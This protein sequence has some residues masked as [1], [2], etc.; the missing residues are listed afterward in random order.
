MTR[1]WWDQPGA[2]AQMDRGTPILLPG[3]GGTMLEQM[4]ERIR[5]F[6][7]EWRD[8]SEED[9][10]VALVRLFGTQLTPIVERAGRL[11]QK[12]LIEYLRVAG[13]GLAPPRPARAFVQFEPRPQN[14]APVLIPDGFRLSS[15]RADGGSGGVNWETEDVLSVGNIVLNEILAFD[16]TIGRAAK[17]GERLAPF[18]ERPVLGAALYLGFAVTGTPGGSIALL[19]EPET[20]GVPA[21]VSEGGAPPPTI[22]RPVLRWEALTARGFVTAAETR[23]DSDRLTRTGLT[24]LKLPAG[25]QA[26]RP[27]GGADGPPLHWLRLRFAS[28]AMRSPSRLAG[29]YPHVVMAVARET[30]REEYPV[31]EADGR[32][33][34]ARLSRTPVLTGSVVLE[35]DEGAVGANLF[36]IAAPSAS[37]GFRRWREVP[38]LAGQRPDARVFTLDGATGTIRFGD[39]REGMSPPQGNRNIA[40]RAY[41]TSLGS[42]GNVGAGGIGTIVSQLAGIQGVSNPL[43]ASG[44]ADAEFAD[45]A[46]ARGPAMVKARGRAVTAGDVALLAAEAEGADIVRAYALPCVDPAFPGAVRPGTI[47]V[48]VIARRHRKD[49]S[50]GPPAATSVTLGAVAAHLAGTA[51]PLGARVV[52]ANPRFHEVIVEAIVTVAAGRDAAAAVHAASEALDRYLNP[53][54][55]GEW[56]IG[57]VLRHSRIV[58]V[59]LGA[60]PDIVSVSFLSLT[61]DGAGNPACAD[62]P[63][64]RFGLPWPGR[65]RLLA[66]AEE[67]GS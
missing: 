28:G 18:G 27:P 62:V 54:R 25:W 26:G 21:P 5:G 47:G 6:T 17:A 64:S 40:V 4:R 8:L 48:F 65:H 67:S 61:V 3:G 49:I 36:D 57:T 58:H 56:A 44:G 41:A 12:A 60:S 32:A 51:G 29:I 50:S 10:G 53:E 34:I 15:P 13:I 66:E 63:L 14:D 38:T 52:A 43:P 46:I 59:V 7:P 35:V 1:P 23:D 37:G 39:Q 9:A 30:H 20:M 45:A 2:E 24:I 22:P 16:G 42:A 33:V 31:R 11:P 19:F 55:D